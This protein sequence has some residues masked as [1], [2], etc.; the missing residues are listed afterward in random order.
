MSK[1]YFVVRLGSLGLQSYENKPQKTANEWQTR[2]AKKFRRVCRISTSR[3]RHPEGAGV[4]LEAFPRVFNTSQTRKTA[5]KLTRNELGI[6]GHAQTFN[7]NMEIFL[8]GF[9][10]ILLYFCYIKPHPGRDAV[11]M[12]RG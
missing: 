2:N 8:L 10:L 4:R 12:M 11:R 9:F 7:Q 5:H 3:W 1:C 6:H